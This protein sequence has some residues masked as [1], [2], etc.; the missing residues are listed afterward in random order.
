MVHLLVLHIPAS[1]LYRECSWDLALLVLHLP[2][3]SMVRRVH[4]SVYVSLRGW[5]VISLEW[6][7]LSPPTRSD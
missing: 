2:K 4:L 7:S 3:D 6:D 5:S 1:Q